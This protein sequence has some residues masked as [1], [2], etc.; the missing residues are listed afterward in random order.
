MTTNTPPR[1]VFAFLCLAVLLAWPTGL[2]AQSS[3]PIPLDRTGTPGTTTATSLDPMSG[4]PTTI[5]VDTGA[6]V[7]PCTL[8]NVDV[9]GGSTISTTQ[10]VDRFGTIKVTVSVVS[11]GTGFGWVPATDGSQ[12]PTGSTYTFSD[13]QHF[14]FRI[15]VGEEFSSDFSDK[16]ALK[17]ARS[18]DNWII[19]AHFRIKI[20]ALG[21]PQVFLIKTT[22]DPTC[23]G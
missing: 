17:G 5:T 2:A 7:N 18:I 8:E 23:K 6:F 12:S 13:S 1:V 11:K 16:F 22:A 3:F 21:E 10:S 19:R 14:T 4:D 15:F 9:T 20:N